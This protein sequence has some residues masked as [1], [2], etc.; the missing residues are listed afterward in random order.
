MVIEWSREQR[1]DAGELVDLLLLFSAHFPLQTRLFIGGRSSTREEQAEFS[2]AMSSR[3]MLAQRLDCLLSRLGC[4]LNPSLLS[5]SLPLSRSFSLGLSGRALSIEPRISISRRNRVSART[6]ESPVSPKP[7]PTRRDQSRGNPTLS[8]TRG[9]LD[10]AVKSVHFSSRRSK[11]TFELQC[12][13]MRNRRKV[14]NST[15]L[16]LEPNLVNSICIPAC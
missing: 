13:A 12:K 10:R 14:R 4:G 2:P 15:G 11:E 9:R 1:R 6:F 7:D 5:L 16:H 3:N 8:R